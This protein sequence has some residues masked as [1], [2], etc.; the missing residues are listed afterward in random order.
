LKKSFAMLFAIIF[1]VVVGTIGM[2]MMYFASNT[3]RQTGDN[4][5]ALQGELYAKS[6]TEFAIQSLE[7]RDYSNDGCID[8]IDINTSYYDIN[9]TFH[10][11]FTKCPTNCNNCSEIGTKES[12]GTVMIN[13][14][15]SSKCDFITIF[16][17]TLQK[18]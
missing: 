9:M 18:P 3:V 4:Y 12:N 7:G 5:T 13:T 11:F 16:R 14:Y 6:A 1:V 10:Y 15:V 8:K 2:M 17:Q